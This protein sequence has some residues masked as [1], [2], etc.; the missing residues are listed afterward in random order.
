VRAKRKRVGAKSQ[1]QAVKKRRRTVTPLLLGFILLIVVF[2]AYLA[3]TLLNQNQAINPESSQPKAAIVDH[4]SLTYPNQTFIQTATTILEQAGYTVDY[5][6]GE[7]VTV[8]FYG[9]LPT[10]GYSLIILRVHSTTGGYASLYLFTSEPYSGSKY[11]SEQLTD[12]VAAVAYSTEEGNKGILYFGIT[13]LF[14]ESCMKGRFSN[15]VIIMMGCEGLNNTL[16]ARAFVQKGAKVY[17]GWSAPIT[18][19]HTDTATTRLMKH[20]LIEKQTLKVAVQET[21]REVGFDPAFRSLLI[22]YPLEV[23]EQTIDTLRLKAET[24]YSRR[25]S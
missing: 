21:F 12:K 9:N 22:Y 6:P 5:Y 19:S 25:S 18:A 23:G 15:T 11:V 16:M 14:V 10:H 2:S 24:T 1:I 7:E 8:E 17:I 3:Y 20:L 13:H 4:L